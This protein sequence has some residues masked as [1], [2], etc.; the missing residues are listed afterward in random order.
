MRTEIKTLVINSLT[1]TQK[2]RLAIIAD[3]EILNKL[4][5]KVLYDVEIF[6]KK[7]LTEALELNFKG[8]EF[9]RVS[10]CV[11]YNNNIEI[12]AFCKSI[13]EITYPAKECFVE[14]IKNKSYISVN[15]DDQEIPKGYRVAENRKDWIEF[16]VK[17][18]NFD[19]RNFVT[20]KEI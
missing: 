18:L 3:D 16:D 6:D 10:A 12:Q 14:A 2:L 4:F 13:E 7:G 1:E 9:E 20:W 8:L 11:G 5:T 17:D 19:I 15:S